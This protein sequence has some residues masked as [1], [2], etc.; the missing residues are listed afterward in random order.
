MQAKPA[1]R[2]KKFFPK[3]FKDNIFEHQRNVLQMQWIYTMA[4]V[5]SLTHLNALF[6]LTVCAFLAGYQIF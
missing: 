6:S 4:E 1:D 5:R 3:M 2:N